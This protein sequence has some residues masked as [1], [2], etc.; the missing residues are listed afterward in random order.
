V[1]KSVWEYFQKK[2]NSQDGFWWMRKK[3]VSWE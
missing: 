2:V 3:G 1:T